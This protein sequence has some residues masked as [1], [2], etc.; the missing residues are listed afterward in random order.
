MVASQFQDACPTHA[1]FWDV[2]GRPFLP[3]PVRIHPATLAMAGHRA[4]ALLLGFAACLALATGEQ[5]DHAQALA[6]AVRSWPLWMSVLAAHNAGRPPE[7]HVWLQRPLSRECREVPGRLGAA[8]RKAVCRLSGAVRSVQGGVAVRAWHVS[9][10]ADIAFPSETTLHCMVR[11]ATSAPCA[12]LHQN[13]GTAVQ[14]VRPTHAEQLAAQ[15]ATRS[16]STSMHMRKAAFRR[17][18]GSQAPSAGDDVDI[19]AGLLPWLLATG[20]E[21]PCTLDAWGLC[22][23]G[24]VNVS[25]TPYRAW[26][27]RALS[28]QRLLQDPLPL[29]W[30]QWLT[31]HNSFNAAPDVWAGEVVFFRALH[32]AIA[33]ATNGSAQWVWNQQSF[34]VPDQLNMG[35][36][37]VMF[38]PWFVFGEVRVCHAGGAGDIPGLQDIIAAIERALHWNTTFSAWDIGCTPF[39]APLTAALA[40]VGQWVDQHPNATLL[41]SLNDFSEHQLLGREQVVHDALQA[42]LGPRLLTPAMQTQLF[43]GSWPSPAAM[44][45]VRSFNGSAVRPQVMARSGGTLATGSVFLDP[46]WPGWTANTLPHLQAY[47]ACGSG[48]GGPFPG[49]WRLLDGESMNLPPF[50]K[51][52]A[53]YG[54]LGPPNLATAAACGVSVAKADLVSPDLAAAAVWSWAPFEPRNTSACP[55][56]AATVPLPPLSHGAVWDA[57]AAIGRWVTLPCSQHGIPLACAGA[58]AA[59]GNMDWFLVPAPSTASSAGRGALAAP[60]QDVPSQWATACAKAGGTLQ[61]PR[62][63]VDN[64]ELADLM[65]GKGLAHVWLGV[66]ADVLAA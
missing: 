61:A 29:P 57:A 19:G 33:A 53:D 41:L 36:R 52:P 47:P 64:R 62:T 28:S 55:A 58:S 8:Q 20:T 59:P 54:L 51:G 5:D 17:A 21:T 46:T 24:T 31:S 66:P 38:D 2:S 56:M 44:Q 60:E 6:E 37:G 42:A 14:A 32:D 30:V 26:A 45:A 25:S 39:D 27:S 35:V 15:E 4:V 40:Q 49:S 12:A 63:A 13:H 3:H 48:S 9:T 10:P 18:K 50:Y 1:S 23:A 16:Y 34:A 7:Q 65:R 43:N 22:E 11:R